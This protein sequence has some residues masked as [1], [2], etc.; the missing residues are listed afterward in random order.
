MAP[1]LK[2]V[3]DW[4]GRLRTRC[5]SHLWLWER[6]VPSAGSSLHREN[7]PTESSQK[8]PR[9]TAAFTPAKVPSLKSHA[10]S[11]RKMSWGRHNPVLVS[12]HGSV[13]SCCRNLF[14]GQLEHS[15][16]SA[17]QQVFGIGSD[18]ILQLP[19]LM[20][21]SAMGQLFSPTLCCGRGAQRGH[22]TP[23][24][25]PLSLARILR[26]LARLMGR[27]KTRL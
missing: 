15:A 27:A 25:P 18:T 19:L 13:T 16:S 9:L 22:S 24:L 4:C 8:I 21:S 26:I 17:A 2:A 20:V 1:F 6:E 12:R 11:Y 3:P 10:Q 14:L 23:A 7:T 5:L